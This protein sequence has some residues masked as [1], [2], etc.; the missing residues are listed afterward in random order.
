MPTVTARKDRRHSNDCLWRR[1]PPVEQ[2]HRSKPPIR[3]IAR[4]GHG[5]RSAK[6]A[7]PP[8][9]YRRWREP[10]KRKLSVALLT[11]RLRNHRRPR[12]CPGPG[13]PAHGAA[14]AQLR[15]R[16]PKQPC[17]PPPRDLA[18]A[19]HPGAMPPPRSFGPGPP[20]C[21]TTAQPVE[22]SQH[23]D[24]RG[25]RPLNEIAPTAASASAFE[26]PG[27]KFSPDATPS[28]R[29]EKPHA[30]EERW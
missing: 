10:G 2:R 18:I 4:G 29:P 25:D 14:R 19:A 9:D 30:L 13:V 28:Q 23:A 22:C 6:L 5:R 11:Q 21:R 12:R 27:W 20:C 3:T 15:I 16:R 26:H 1:C 24:G 8:A 17:Q 7:Q